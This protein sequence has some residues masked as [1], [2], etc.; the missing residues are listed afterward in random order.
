MSFDPQKLMQEELVTRREPDDPLYRQ[1]L[2]AFADNPFLDL[3][4][5]HIAEYTKKKENTGTP[6]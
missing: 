5:D 1:S 4:K 3:T 6:S 2:N